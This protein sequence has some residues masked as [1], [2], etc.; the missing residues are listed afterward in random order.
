MGSTPIQGIIFNGMGLLAM[1]L[2]EFE[3]WAGVAIIVFFLLS[4]G[5]VVWLW[6]GI[7]GKHESGDDD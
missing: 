1:T 7:N 3:L 4:S 2:E 6:K 5:L